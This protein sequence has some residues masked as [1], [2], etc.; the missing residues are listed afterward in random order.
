MKLVQSVDR[1][2]L[3]SARLVAESSEF[4]IYDVG[5]DAYTLVHRHEGRVERAFAEHAPEKI[6]Q[7]ESDEEGVRDEAR[8]ERCGDQGVPHEAQQ[9][10]ERGRAADEEHGLCEGHG[11]RIA[12]PR[13]KLELRSDFPPVI[14]ERTH[15]LVP[16]ATLSTLALP[17]RRVNLS[18]CLR[19]AGVKS[20][21][22][23]GGRSSAVRRLWTA[24][25]A[26]KASSM[27]A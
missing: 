19:S 22:T 4:A 12:L 11:R 7:A 16:S 20:E 3:E 14:P 1:K 26:A 21:A 23:A 17:S 2:S 27:K 18:A 15:P 13:Q 9:S 24:R 10:R 25:Y 6:R 8:S 5:G